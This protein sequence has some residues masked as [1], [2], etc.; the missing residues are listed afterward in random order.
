MKSLWIFP[1]TG[2][3]FHGTLETQNNP[4][5]YGNFE[6]QNF[7]FAACSVTQV[8]SRNRCCAE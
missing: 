8:A 6:K 4:C 1:K 3:D 5:P 7:K 2:R